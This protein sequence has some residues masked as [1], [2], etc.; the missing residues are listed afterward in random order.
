MTPHRRLDIQADGA[1]GHIPH[2][3]DDLL[4]GGGELGAHGEAQAIGQLRGRAPAQKVAGRGV[5]GFSVAVSLVFL[6]SSH[7]ALV[8]RFSSCK[9]VS[10]ARG[11]PA[12]VVSASSNCRS[13]NLASP[14]TGTS[15]W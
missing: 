10:S 13:T 6:S 8:A 5:A 1:K 7:A 15:H 9:A 14:S 12:W 3:I 2:H 4:V 11:A